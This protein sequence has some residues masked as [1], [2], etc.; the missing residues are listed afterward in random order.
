MSN[1]HPDY[2][3]G[4][5]NFIIQSIPHSKFTRKENDLHTEIN[6]SLAEV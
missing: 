5:L 2:T 1:E 3:A 6:I 4:D